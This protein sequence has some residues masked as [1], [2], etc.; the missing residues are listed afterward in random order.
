[1]KMKRM[2]MLASIGVSSFSP[3]FA[4]EAVDMKLLGL[5]ELEWEATPE[6]VGFAPLKGDRFEEGYIAMVRLPA[7]L[8]SPLHVKSA[9]MSGV[10]LTGEIVHLAE[11]IEGG[12]AKGLEA[13]AFYEIPAGIPHISKCV[14]ADDCLTFLVQ[15]GPFDFLPVKEGGR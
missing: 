11:N 15:D 1:M 8:S 6:G 4:A 9:A 14:S 5:E 2:M 12:S 3:A 10:V 7:G 13:G